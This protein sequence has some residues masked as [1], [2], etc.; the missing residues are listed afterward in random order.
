MWA[1]L[2]RRFPLW[3]LLAVAAPVP[4]GLLGTGRDWLRLRARGSLAGNR[5]QQEPSD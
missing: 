1:F 3:L 2:S 5:G 4:S